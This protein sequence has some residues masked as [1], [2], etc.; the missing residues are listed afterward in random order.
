[1]IRIA[2]VI[3]GLDVGGAEMM[4]YKLLSAG[5]RSRFESRVYC[6]TGGGP[7]AERIEALGVPVVALGA[8]GGLSFLAALPRLTGA[9][10]AFA[11]DVVQTWL[12]HADLAGLLVR[13]WL[14]DARLCWNLRCSALGPGEYPWTTRALVR[15]LGWLSPLPSLVMANS[16]AGRAAHAAVGYRPRR[17]ELVANGFDTRI[18]RPD[19]ALRLALRQSLAIPADAPVIGMAGRYHPMKDHAGFLHAARRLLDARPQ[20]HFVLAGRE[21]D[22][23]NAPLRA[24][25]MRLGLRAKVHLLGERADVAAVMNGLDVFTLCSVM[26][27]GFPNVVGEAMACAL[28]CVVTDVG[29]A[30]AVLGDA[31]LVV[32]PSDAAAL[33]AAWLELLDLPAAERHRLGEAARARVEEHYSLAAAVGRYERIY[34]GLAAQTSDGG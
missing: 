11:P 27:E 14:G 34:E 1:M 6:L 20:A 5:D 13:P 24:L 25:V 12:Y 17:W 7:M 15:T 28:S 31:G 9:L 29:D 30:R 26:G 23:A 21:V 2:H 16:A 32:P 33:A 8:R 19:A 10:R 22:D 18:F 4:L 3:T